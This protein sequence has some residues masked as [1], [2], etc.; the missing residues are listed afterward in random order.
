MAKKQKPISPIRAPLLLGLNIATGFF[1]LIFLG[2]RWDEHHGHTYKGLIIGIILS[3][4]YCI[5]EI[6]KTIRQ[7]NEN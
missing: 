3:L 4:A 1:L 2:H 6:W 7:I 5:Y